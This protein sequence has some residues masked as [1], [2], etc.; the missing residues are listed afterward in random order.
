MDSITHIVLGACVGEAFFEKGFGKRAMIWGALA[1]SLPDIDFITAFYMETPDALLAHRG[2][3]HSFLFV[4]FSAL[5]L[6][7]LADRIHK[8]RNIR[9]RTWFLFFITEL[10]LHV[11]IDVFNN[12]GVGWLEPFSHDRFSWD[13]IYVADPF[14][15][16]VPGV[17]CLLLIV[18]SAFH[19]RRGL[20]WRVGLLV[21]LLYVFYAMVHKYEVVKDVE[22]GVSTATGVSGKMLVT[23]APF[24]HW[25]W[26]VV[27]SERNGYWLGYRSVFDT[28]SYR[29]QTFVPQQAHWLEDVKDHES[30][31]KLVRFSRGF[32]SV[33]RDARGLLLNNL[34]FGQVLGW[35]YPDRG[36]VFRYYLS[37][38][39]DSELLIQQG[40]IQGWSMPEWR[41]YAA[42]V[43]SV[44]DCRLK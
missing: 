30:L 17:A 21:P 25:L 8:P 3:T 19:P 20:W 9:M 32:Y 15:S 43:F 7:L 6:A 24:Q 5:L 42:R 1:Q 18:Q 38:P 39:Q 40:R 34:R 10:M 36:F 44:R 2:F 11:F 12:Y 27:I 14:F 26:F 35:R 16:L 22:A 41:Y 37:H 4:G 23:P 29:P 31:Q 13:L 33:D 28:G